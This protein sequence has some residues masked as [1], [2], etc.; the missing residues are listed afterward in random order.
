MSNPLCNCARDN[1]FH[2]VESGIPN[3]FPVVFLVVALIVVN[4]LDIGA[5]FHSFGKGIG[6]WLILE[7][8]EGG[9]Q[10]ELAVFGEADEACERL[11]QASR[12]PDH[13]LGF[14]VVTVRFLI[15]KSAGIR[16]RPDDATIEVDV[17][18]S[19][20]VALVGMQQILDLSRD[21][22]RYGRGLVEFQ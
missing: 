10:G 6:D 17:M 1:R 15:P 13:F 2:L 11:E 4:D 12:E 3:R 9:A 20:I 18:G 7:F 14:R 21:F 5:C 16:L 22:D 19:F 8:V